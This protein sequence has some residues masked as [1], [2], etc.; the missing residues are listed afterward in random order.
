MIFKAGPGLHQLI[1]A[2]EHPDR[3]LAVFLVNDMSVHSHAHAHVH[4]HLHVVRSKADQLQW[5]Q[6]CGVS[7]RLV[8]KW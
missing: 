1:A 8:G 4:V 6:M 2:P 7:C 5:D 3:D